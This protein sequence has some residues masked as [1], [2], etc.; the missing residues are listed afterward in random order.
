MLHQVWLIFVHG[1]ADSFQKDASAVSK[2]PERS[3]D[4]F[5]CGEATCS[6]VGLEKEDETADRWQQDE[7]IIP[8]V[9]TFRVLDTGN[10]LWIDMAEILRLKSK[11]GVLFSEHIHT[12]RPS[13][14]VLLEPL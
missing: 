14:H 3:R 2:K 11:P 4:L 5:T 1:V 9:H 12:Q 6:R 8:L 13:G 7:R 10:H